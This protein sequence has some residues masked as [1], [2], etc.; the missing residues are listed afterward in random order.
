[1]GWEYVNPKSILS[2]EDGECRIGIEPGAAIA[3]IV[4]DTVINAVLTAIFLWQL[5]PGMRSSIL[6]IPGHAS[7][8][9]NL[10]RDLS[11]RGFLNRMQE[12]HELTR[13]SSR[14]SLRKMLIRNVVGSSLLFF[15]MVCNKGLYLTLTL[16]KLGHTCLLMCLTEG[17]C[18]LRNCLKLMLKLVLVVIGMLVV[19]WL[20]MRSVEE[21]DRQPRM[22]FSFG[23]SDFE[24]PI[25]RVPDTMTR[26]ND[27]P[28]PISHT[29]S[30]RKNN[31]IYFDLR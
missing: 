13:I 20:T 8:I 27:K 4:L 23:R 22:S 12:K 9:T 6:H 21:E 15:V 11:I 29:I 5:R 18:I 19:Q 2:R 31:D 7:D 16:A 28:V 14:S 3:I 25:T 1:M 26:G 30:E 17:K 24:L 10:E